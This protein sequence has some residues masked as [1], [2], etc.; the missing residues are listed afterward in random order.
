LQTPYSTDIHKRL[1]L[2]NPEQF[3]IV[4]NFKLQI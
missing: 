4:K 3:E 2:K 1:I